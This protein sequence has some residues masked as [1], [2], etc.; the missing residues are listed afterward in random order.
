MNYSDIK[1]KLT[2]LVVPARD[3]KCI[4][5][6]VPHDYVTGTDDLMIIYCIDTAEI[7]PYSED[8]YLMLT[9]KSLRTFGITKEQL[10]VDTFFNVARSATIQFCLDPELAALNPSEKP[11]CVATN[12]DLEYGASVLAYPGFLEQASAILGGNYYVVPSSIHDVILI[13]EDQVDDPID[14]RDFFR[15]VNRDEFEP[16]EWL[17]NNLYHFDVKEHRFEIV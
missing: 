5:R 3:Y 17:S 9:N 10:C 2:I 6:L 13:P 11:V 7:N 16:E 1:D 14:L 4:A 8:R 15:Q 12:G